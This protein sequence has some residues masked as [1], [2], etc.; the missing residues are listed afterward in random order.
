MTIDKHKALS[1]YVESCHGRSFDLGRFDCFTFTNDA[2]R[3]M[4]GKGYADPIIGKY[5]GLGPKGLVELIRDTYGEAD[6]VAAFNRHMKRVDGI[7]PKGALIIT[8]K[9]GRWITGRAL[10]IAMGVT[11]AFVADKGLIH[12][13]IT[14]IEGAWV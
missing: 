14:D 11:G 5:A 8:D 12:L 13:P 1:A 10:G 3:A 6:M 2:W 4:H 9:V 7:P